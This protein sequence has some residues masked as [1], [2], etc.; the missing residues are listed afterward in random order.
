MRLRTQPRS[1]PDRVLIAGVEGVGKSSLAASAPRSAILAAEDGTDHI[2]RDP[3]FDAQVITREDGSPLASW[4][5][6]MESLAWLATGE[7]DR[8]TLVVDSIDWLEKAA[9]AHLCAERG[10]ED[11]EAP[12]YGKGYVAATDLWR[13]FIAAL[14]RCRQRGITVILVAH[15]IVRPFSNPAG[16]DYHRF[17]I[18]LHKGAAALSKEW[19]DSVLFV[20]WE[21]AVAAKQD[22]RKKKGTATG[23]RIVHA[24]RDAAWD[25]KSRWGV[26]DAFYLPDDPAA[27]WGT[28]VG[29]REAAGIFAAAPAPAAEVSR[30][31]SPRVAELMTETPEA[32]VALGMSLAE[33][34]GDVDKRRDAIAYIEQ[35]TTDVA[36]LAKL[37]ARIEET[38]L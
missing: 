16:F 36:R 8:E 21:E 34:L 5:D 10:W 33:A 17:E 13:S 25:A 31:P 14:E 26:P 7:H 12:G 24:K 4:T 30:G 6:A 35:D 20:T 19:C 22:E 18:A 2:E 9:W 38:I 3:R 28:Y 23:K 27:G 37:I 11:I 1:L 15:S 32:L 29:H